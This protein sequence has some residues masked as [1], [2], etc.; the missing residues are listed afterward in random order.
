MVIRMFFILYC[1]FSLAA[2][3]A[4]VTVEGRN[5]RIE[6]DTALRSHVIAKLGGKDIRIGEPT[7][8]EFL[9]IAGSDRREFTMTG[10]KQES[11]RDQLGQ[12]RKWVINGTS[13]S[14]KKTVSVTTYNEFPAFAFF[15][16]EYT[17]GGTED[18][19]V[20]SWTSNSYSISAPAAGE[21]AFWSY[22]SGSYKNRPDWV[23][24]LKPGFTQGNFLGMNSSDY[25]GG[26][27]IVD[28]WHKSAGIAVGH[29]ENG[30]RLVSLPV[31]Q[32][33]AQSATVAVKFES[34]RSL[35]PGQTLKT[36][37][38]FAA[39]HQGDYFST[40]AAYR[41]VMAKQGMQFDASP[42][43]A[44]GPIWCAWG[45][46]RNFTPSQVYGALPI[47]KKL[48][49]TWVT[50]DDGWQTNEGDWA[51]QPKKFPNGDSDM[52]AMVNKIHEE[53]FRSQ[54]WWAP[55]AAD[56][57]SDVLRDHPDMLLLNAD[58]SKQRITYW[59]AWYMCPASPKVVEYHRSLVTR[60]IKDWDYDG[61]KLD[62]QHMN[63]VPACYNPA[64]KHAR[65]EESVEALPAFFKAIYDTARAI[66]K[67]AVIEWCPCGTAFSF[68]TLPYMNMSVASDPRGSFQIRSKGKTVKA[69]HGDG[70]AFFGDHVELST[71]RDDFASTVGI[72]GVI[73]TEFT[74]PP[75]SSERNRGALT[76]EREVYF[77]KWLG[78]YKDKMLSRGEYQGS[79]Y[80]IGFDK[81]E[82]HAIRKGRTM[83]YAFYGPKFDGKIELRGLGKGTYR[84]ADYANG[85][86]LGTVR[87]PVGSLTVQFE[88]NLLIEA[89]PE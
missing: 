16:V 73:G 75:N 48:G 79:L 83:Y 18:L 7:A 19:Q 62:G 89:T 65:P 59:N 70:V 82:A 84:V 66:K 87:G 51:L 43:S 56:D 24:P 74:W 21:P 67:D 5:I 39:V 9:T 71:G 23:L 60:M 15:E 26:T 45:Y 6:F 69:L 44:F 86:S 12:G 31:S 34:K 49:F 38:T 80:D 14:L 32:P 2:S 1:S 77:A 58:G 63:G 41:K 13:Q 54:L 3:A 50:L 33:D 35:K 40:L 30:P 8:S 72:G 20:D 61:L 57:P 52:K 17:N 64:H 25:G 47:V 68:H 27:P 53:G 46:G 28:V 37:K 81:P 42:E 10:Q 55:L 36:L 11:V 78:I 85:K 88:K 29:I 76:P 22:Q 4:G